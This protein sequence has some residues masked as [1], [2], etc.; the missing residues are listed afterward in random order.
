MVSLL[1]TLNPNDI[2]RSCFKLS[3]SGSCKI[4]RTY[5]AD[6]S[7]DLRMLQIK[8]VQVHI[9]DICELGFP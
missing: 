7:I 4:L 8:T 2:S 1:D 9:K 3:V 5:H 6:F